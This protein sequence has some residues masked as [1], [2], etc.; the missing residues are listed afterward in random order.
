VALADAD[1]EINPDYSAPAYGLPSRQTMDGIRMAAELEAMIT[2]PVYEGKSVA[3][4]I[5]L[6]R[7]GGIRK[8]ARVL[9]VHL[10]GA[11]AVNAYYKAFEDEA[12][13]TR[14]AREARYHEDRTDKEA[15]SGVA[16]AT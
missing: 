15:P 10:G 13:L 7:T 5:D 4:L 9:Y 2:D 12:N 16:S 3:G 11:P 1:I 14:L 6:C 8:D